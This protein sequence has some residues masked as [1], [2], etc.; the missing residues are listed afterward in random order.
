[1]AE[2]TL[3]QDAVEALK[4]GNKARAKELLTLLLKAEQTNATYWLWMSAAVDNPKE[5]IYCLQTAF[6]LD[7]E[8]VTAKR[9]LLLLGALS[10]DETIQPFLLNRPR[11]WEQK[12]LLAHERPRPKGIQALTSNPLARLAAIVGVSVVLIGLVYLGLT[13]PRSIRARQVAVNTAG[14]SPTFSPTPTLFGAVAVSTPTFSGPK[15]LWAQL[16]ETY[17]PTPIYAAATRQ[18]QSADQY[19]VALDAY[20]KGNFDEYI[21][22]MQEVA[23]LEPDSPDLPYLIGNAYLQQGRARESVVAYNEA[24]KIDPKFG[25]AYLGLA[26]ARLLQDPGVDQT[27]LFDLALQYD[28]NFGEIYLERGNYYLYIKDAKSALAD[29]TSAE[30]LMPTSPLVYYGFARAYDLSGEPKKALENADKAFARDLTLLPNY[31]LRGRLYIELERY[32]DAIQ[33]LNTYVLYETKSGPAFA[34]LGEAH[35]K[36]GDCKTAAPLLTKGLTLDSTQHQIYLYRA[37]C[38]LE[39]G[40]PVNAQAD[41]ERAIP[42]FTQTFEIRIGLTQAY[43]NQKKFGSAYQEAEGAMSLAKTDE[44]KALALYWRALSNEGR[45]ALNEAVKD[46]QALLK[47]PASAMTAGMRSTAEDHL[48]KIALMTPSPTPKPSTPTKTKTPVPTGGKKTPTPT[49]T[50]IPSRTPVPS[51]T[52]GSHP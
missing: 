5:R 30:K 48:R 18:P 4:Q 2:D 8:N 52:P 45:A 35:Y 47:L 11:A 32:A 28:P 6:K 34:L 7:P 36:T 1:M 41:F 23:R 21:R 13:L 24:L 40:D 44:Q 46:W 42:F 15:P 49:R 22:N 43:Y 27:A 51:P 33:A 26:R 50:P 12:L 10:P 20:N 14:P 19:R 31:L 3:F 16:V 9:G 38:L 29:F 37:D 25:P 17:T 39:T